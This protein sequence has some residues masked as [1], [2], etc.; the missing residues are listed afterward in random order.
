MARDATDTKQRILDAAKQ[1]VLERGFAG[2]SVDDI[3][4]AAGISRGTFFYH[5]PSKDDLARALIGR[6]AEEDHALI[7]SFMARA[8]KL[9]SD[10]LQQALIFIALHEEMLDDVGPEGCLF[11][12]YS[13]EAG[14][15]DDE[16][17]ALI[18]DALE[19]LRRVFGGKLAQAMERHEPRV[20]GTDPYLL[21]D[22]ASGVMQGAFI[23]RRTLRDPGLM[24][25]HVRHFR[26]YLELLFGVA[27]TDPTREAESS[28]AG[29][30]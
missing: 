11:A 21:A 14:L 30:S 26:N 27:G 2:T 22:V 8:E 29:A 16:T 18:T 1:Q 20:P 17:H 9:S 5:F 12:S 3:Q 15:F 23:M 24:A 6:H 13:Y 25:A 7:D 10:P 19:H 4:K 28:L